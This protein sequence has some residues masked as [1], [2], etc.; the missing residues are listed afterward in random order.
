MVRFLILH[1]QAKSRWFYAG[2][3]EFKYDF[4]ANITD[5]TFDGFEY[6]QQLSQDEAREHFAKY[7]ENL[8][9]FEF[10][11]L[12]PKSFKREYKFALKYS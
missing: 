7:I 6:P 5:V 12:N 11:D 8:D 1:G 4:S 10:V 3:D 9:D 2:D